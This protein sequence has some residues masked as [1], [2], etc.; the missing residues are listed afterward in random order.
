[1]ENI[2][3]NFSSFKNIIE[4]GGGYGGQCYVLSKRINFDTYTIIDLKDV[5]NLQEKYLNKLNIKNVK[6]IYPEILDTIKNIKYDLVISCF[7]WSE[8]SKDIQLL[9]YNEIIKNSKHGFLRCNI[10]F[11][12]HTLVEMRNLF[13]DTSISFLM[14]EVS[15]DEGAWMIYW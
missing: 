1:M 10:C 4:I 5:S 9:Y 11:S 15:N 13:S 12:G 8:L 6:Y 3:S 7:A 2:F 14:D